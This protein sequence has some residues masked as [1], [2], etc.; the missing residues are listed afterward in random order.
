MTFKVL[1]LS[2]ISRLNIILS[3]ALLVMSG[4][5][6]FTAHPVTYQ[7]AYAARIL[8]FSGVNAYINY[9]TS[10]SQAFGVTYRTHYALPGHMGFLQA[11]RLLKRW[12][13][14][15]AQ[16]NIYS[17]L[18]LGALSTNSSLFPC[19]KLMADYENRVWMVSG[20]TSWM[21]PNQQSFTEGQARIGWSP[22]KHSYEGIASWFIV[23]LN[24][25]NQGKK[26]PQLMPVYRG[27][28]KKY[29]WE[30][31]YDGQSLLIHTMVH[32]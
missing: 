18:A 3:F 29:L 6:S 26:S 7:G 10:A 22:Y 5:S 16:A 31:G 21:N 24:I 15:D 19:F 13:F 1:R 9:S 23:Q 27:F 14:F 20:S 4:F 11:N 17:S 28:Y 32:I 25:D 30:L 12:H 8:S 2:S